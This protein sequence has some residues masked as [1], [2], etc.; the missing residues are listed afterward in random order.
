M[1][2]RD[3]SHRYGITFHRKLRKKSTLASELDNI[4]GI[5][6]R[7]KNELLKHIGSLTR[8]RNASLEDLLEVRGIGKELAGEI[9]NYFHPTA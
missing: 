2:I 8:I 4:N 3:E 5:G 7:K 9:F 1:R 6:A